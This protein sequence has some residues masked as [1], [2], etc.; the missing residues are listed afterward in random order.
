M[1]RLSKGSLL[2]YLDRFAVNLWYLIRCSWNEFFRIK[3]VVALISS[4]RYFLFAL[5]FKQR[6]V[7][8]STT[9]QSHFVATNTVA[10]NLKGLRLSEIRAFSGERPDLLL[11]IISVIGAINR[12]TAKIL[13]VGTRAESE[14]FIARSYGFAKANIRGL[15][16]ISYSKLVD[17]GDMHCMPYGDSE[18]DVIVL[19]WVLAYSESPNI[20]C[21]EVRR[22]AKN[23]TI[24]AIGIQYHPLST[25]EIGKSLGYIPGAKA[26]IES[27]EAI[28]SFFEGF[29]DKVFFRHDV[30]PEEMTS[31]G[32][33][34][35]VFS[36]KKLVQN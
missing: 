1:S 21:Q 25:K 34:I 23:G 18:W 11:R 35:L 31:S 4:F 3:I 5:I 19:A 20:A 36:I 22:V 7:L 16:L 33:I 15:D 6:R 30:S 17:L 27:T 29:I 32:E 28:L 10:H 13:F 14:L 9:G 2:H 26:R 24:I 8:D 12:E